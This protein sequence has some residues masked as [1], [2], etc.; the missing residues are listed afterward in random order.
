MIGNGYKGSVLDLCWVGKKA[1]RS[2][3]DGRILIWTP[4]K[5]IPINFMILKSN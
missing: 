5:I 4:F 1:L 3:S 2:G